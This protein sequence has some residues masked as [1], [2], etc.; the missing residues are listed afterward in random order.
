MGF[1]EMEPVFGQLKAEW[2]SAPQQTTPLEPFLF[3]AGPLPNNPSTLRIHV[4]DFHSNT[5]AAVKSHSQLEDMVNLIFFL[6]LTV[7]FFFFFFFFFNFFC[8]FKPLVRRLKTCRGGS[9]FARF[10]YFC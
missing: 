10:F 2:C 4:S 3:L 7:P 8:C 6:G 5:W 1:E 9:F